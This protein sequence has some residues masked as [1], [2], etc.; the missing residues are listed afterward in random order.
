MT[1]YQ[2]LEIRLLVAL[3]QSQGITLHQTIDF[4]PAACRSC[5]AVTVSLLVVPGLLPYAV[6]I[7]STPACNLCGQVG[8]CDSAGIL[9][10]CDTVVLGILTS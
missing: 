1:T 4:Q 2:S 3:V 7:Q 6:T 5:S 8:A 9:L 10:L